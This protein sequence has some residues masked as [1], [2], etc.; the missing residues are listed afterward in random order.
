[1]RSFG[2]SV[3]VAVAAVLAPLA[4]AGAFQCD[5]CVR[6]FEEPERPPTLAWDSYKWGGHWQEANDVLVNPLPKGA[7]VIV[8]VPAIGESDEAVRYGTD[9]VA[10]LF[11]ER[12]LAQTH[13]RIRD[14]PKATGSEDLAEIARALAAAVAKAPKYGYDASRIILV[15]SRWGAQTAALL[16][17]D[18]SWLR[19]AGV[20]FE[21]LRGVVLI[22][23][24]GLDLEHAARSASAFGRKKLAKNLLRAVGA[25]TALSPLRHVGGP[26]A[27]RFLTIAVRPENN[28]V[29]ESQAFAAALRAAGAE[30]QVKLVDRT[31]DA[32]PST[33]LG[34]PSNPD[35]KAVAAFLA[36]AAAP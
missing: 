17:T 5:R 21:S 18:P 6:N 20:D 25:E 12:K 29:G 15:G 9:W 10:S 16:A 30:A 34:H 14:R 1:V 24:M 19:A 36:S 35:S 7:A 2:I 8:W 22:E 32:T 4:A 26:D 13:L 23:P 27:P 28:S 11:Y 3:I 33:E 31:L